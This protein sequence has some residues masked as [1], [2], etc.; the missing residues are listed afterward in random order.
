MRVRFKRPVICHHSCQSRGIWVWGQSLRGART[1]AKPH[2]KAPPSRQPRTPGPG[3]STAPAM[4]P[5]KK[6]RK[7][8]SEGAPPEGPPPD[9]AAIQHQLKELQAQMMQQAKAAPAAPAAQGPA[10]I[11]TRGHASNQATKAKQMA[12]EAATAATAAA[13]KLKS[14]P[15]TGESRGDLLCL[16]SPLLAALLFLLAATGLLQPALEDPS[17]GSVLRSAAVC[18]QP[19]FRPSCC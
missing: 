17:P 3:R 11:T 7:T 6:Q 2:G 8:A 1:L 10:G 9:L 4:P 19:R 13:D 5:R 18:I 12:R 15:L 16:V 14:H